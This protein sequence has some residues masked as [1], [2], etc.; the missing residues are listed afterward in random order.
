MIGLET[1]SSQAV[2]PARKYEWFLN[3]FD[4]Y[5]KF[6]QFLRTRE[7]ILLGERLFDVPDEELS[8]RELMG[9]LAFNLYET[10]LAG[11]PAAGL[12]WVFQTVTHTESGLRFPT[13]TDPF[14]Q[15]VLREMNQSAGT[16]EHVSKAFV[17]PGLLLVVAVI[18]SWASLHQSDSTKESRRRCRDAFLYYDGAFGLFPQML[19]S[20]GLVLVVFLD[21]LGPR[22]NE[23]FAG[24]GLIVA[25]PVTAAGVWQ[26]YVL[27]AEIP[28]NLFDLNGYKETS[29][30]FATAAPPRPWKRFLS[31]TIPVTFVGIP[32]LAYVLEY[33]LIL[34]FCCVC[35][36]EG[37][38]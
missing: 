16:I 30:L 4:R 1:R 35:H 34:A 12:A 33:A 26:A 28:R 37:L 32:A 11:L 21:W 5:K 10:A 13:S 15:G 23:L 36:F 14:W 38:A 31:V 8:K 29:G 20:L 18:A 7:A 27:L 6:R 24:L 19:S 17:V 25:L 22:V 9:P 3:H 2:P